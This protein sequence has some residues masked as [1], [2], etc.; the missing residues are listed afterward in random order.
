MKTQR[1]IYRILFDY[2]KGFR[3]LFFMALL[4]AA[5]NQ[6]FSL[7]EPLVTGKIMDTCVLMKDKLTKNEFVFRV[8]QLISIAIGVALVSRICKNIQDYFVS[9]LTQ[10]VGAQIYADG[11]KHSLKQSFVSFEDKR[12]GETLSVLQ[13]VRTDVEKLITVFVSILFTSLIGVFFVFFYTMNVSGWVGLIYLLAIPLVGFMSSFLGKKIK[14]FQKKIVSE[15]N[16]LSGTTTESLRNIELIKSLGLEKQELERL[17]LNTEKILQLEIK[18]IKQIRS[19]SFLQ[20]TVV[21]LTRSV[22]IFVLMILIFNNEITP[23]QY[24]T[25]LFFSF[26]IFNPLQEFGS[27][28][29]VFRETQVSLNAFENLMN[30]PIEEKPV[31]SVPIGKLES[32]EF[33]GVSF[34]HNSGKYNAISKVSFEIK[35]GETIAFVGPSGSGKTTLVKMLIGLY[36]PSEGDVFYNSVSRFKMDHTELKSQ[37][38]LVTQDT[39]LFSGTIKDNLLFVKPDASDFQI[40]QALKLASCDSLLNRSSKGMDSMIG[41]SGIKVSGGERQRISIARALLR[42]PTLLVF[43]EA[44]SALDSLTEEEINSTIRNITTDGKHITVLVAHRLSSVIHANMILVLEKG[45]IVESGRHEELLASKGLYYA[46]WRQQ[47][48]ERKQ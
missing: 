38:G 2:V 22:M 45:E 18:K 24:L 9:V 3:G 30:S 25:F 5:F 32:I 7:M 26:F 8:A 12:S 47:I 39:Q 40:S 1:S 6:S 36:H 4:M 35:K 20:G 17:N 29:L 43:D 13:K 44:T 15:T 27:V 33:R 46:M 19:L 34:K 16:S 11:L 10:K 42:E 48:G 14:E 41:E 21:N 28:I 37:L 23:G 31:E